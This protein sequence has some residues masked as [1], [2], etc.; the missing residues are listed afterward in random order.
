MGAIY[1]KVTGWHFKDI[2]YLG[3][4]FV[5]NKRNILYTQ[6]CKVAN[7]LVCTGTAVGWTSID[8][9]LQESFYKTCKY[10]I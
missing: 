4:T 5:N 2:L 3:F 9:K 10:D 8:L 6:K 1:I 7:C